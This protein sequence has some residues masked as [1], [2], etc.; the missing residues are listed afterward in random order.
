MH[1]TATT[2]GD[3]LAQDPIS[4]VHK[5]FSDTIAENG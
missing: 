3:V 4:P 2:N 5:V 1:D